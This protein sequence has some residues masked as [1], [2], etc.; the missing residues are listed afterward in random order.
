MQMTSGRA[1]GCLKQAGRK[2]DGW[3]RVNGGE[4]MEGGVEEMADA[5]EAGRPL[6]ELWGFFALR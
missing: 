3:K 6:E 4:E 2:S 1:L 5:V